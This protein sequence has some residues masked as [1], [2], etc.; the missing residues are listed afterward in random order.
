VG[1]SIIGWR[2]ANMKL[3][4]IAEALNAA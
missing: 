2:D 1:L 4:A 3:L